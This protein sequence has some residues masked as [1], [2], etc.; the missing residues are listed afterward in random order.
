MREWQFSSRRSNGSCLA[1]R[2]RKRCV[3]AVDAL[4]RS[5]LELPNRRKWRRSSDG[6]IELEFHQDQVRAGRASGNWRRTLSNLHMGCAGQPG[7]RYSI[8]RSYSPRLRMQSGVAHLLSS[9][10]K[11]RNESKNLSSSAGTGLPASSSIITW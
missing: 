9:D 7:L 4:K 11:I 8:S 1:L 2:C 10:Y 3:S 5:D 6:I